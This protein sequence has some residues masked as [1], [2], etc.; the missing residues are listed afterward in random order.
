MNSFPVIAVDGD[1][2]KVSYAAYPET[3]MFGVVSAKQSVAADWLNV[4]T[5]AGVIDATTGVNK[6]RQM[7]ENFQLYAYIYKV[8]S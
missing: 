6:D 1:Q 5:G 2:T 7:L 8:L 4:S 3:V